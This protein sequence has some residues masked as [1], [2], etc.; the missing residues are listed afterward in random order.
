MTMT[1]GWV[2]APAAKDPG[3]VGPGR[4]VLRAVP[5]R[6][7]HCRP[8]QRG[9]ALLLLGRGQRLPAPPR[10]FRNFFRKRDCTRGNSG[11]AGPPRAT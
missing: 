7:V 10:A 9:V 4:Q 3:P 6:P 2:G 1:V 11:K 8:V 5:A